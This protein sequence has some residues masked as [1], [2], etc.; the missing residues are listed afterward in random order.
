MDGE[1][2]RRAQLQRQW[3][4]LM[5]VNF[6]ESNPMPVKAALAMMGLLEPVYRL[7]MV[8]PQARVAREDRSGARSFG[9]LY[10][11]LCGASK[12]M[13]DL[14]GRWKRCSRKPAPYTRTDFALFAEFKA[15]AERGRDSR[16][17][18]RSGAPPDGA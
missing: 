4:P 11:S 12:I 9:V 15:A 2:R 3:L 1:F 6:I 17:G 16:R 18:A 5:E 10:G 7:P 8:A 14:R 13:A